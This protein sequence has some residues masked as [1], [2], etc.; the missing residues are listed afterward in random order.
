M[1]NSSNVVNTKEYSKNPLDVDR[2]G[3]GAVWQFMPHGKEM[4]LNGAEG[5]KEI[6]SIHHERICCTKQEKYLAVI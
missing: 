1:G 4:S 5:R 3:T 2:R 6:D